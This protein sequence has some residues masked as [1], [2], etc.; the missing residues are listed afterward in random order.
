MSTFA[1]GGVQGTASGLWLQ[2]GSHC[3]GPLGPGAQER[4]KDEGHPCGPIADLYEVSGYPN[5]PADQ[6]QR[7]AA[8]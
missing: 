2:S 5:R 3:G 6:L 8:Q 4:R 7:K 1:S